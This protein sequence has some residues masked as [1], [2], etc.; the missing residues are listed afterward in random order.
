MTPEGKA[1]SRIKKFLQ[2]EGWYVI[3]IISASPTG[4]PDLIAFKKE[5]I[6]WTEV[7]TETGKLSKLQEFRHKEIKKITDCD[8]MVPY[9]FEDFIQRYNELF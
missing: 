3:K 1:Q 7:K 5:N 9:G 8:V 6:L 4:L 2:K